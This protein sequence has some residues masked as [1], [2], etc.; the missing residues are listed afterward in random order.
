MSNIT[1]FVFLLESI[2]GFEIMF[3]ST[4]REISGKAN[5]DNF[6]TKCDPNVVDFIWENVNENRNVLKQINFLPMLRPSK[7]VEFPIIYPEKVQ[8]SLE[9]NYIENNFTD[10]GENYYK[11]LINKGNKV[12]KKNKNYEFPS[13]APFL[14]A[15]FETISNITAQTCGGTLLSSHWVLTAASCLDLLPSFYN[16]ITKQNNIHK[17]Y[18]TIVANGK[19]PLVD[20]TIHNVTEIFLRPKNNLTTKKNLK[21]TDSQIA[22][23][24]IEPAANINTLKIFNGKIKQRSDIR[25]YGWTLQK[26]STGEYMAVSSIS[27]KFVN[28]DKCKSKNI[29]VNN[30]SMIC[31][32]ADDE[33]KIKISQMSSGG[34]VLVR[35][36]GTLDILAVAEI[37]TTSTILANTLTNNNW[38]HDIV[39]NEIND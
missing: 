35:S 25:V 17:S 31:L 16:N 28:L 30:N 39:N 36:Q 27:T 12:Y 19:N 15:I 11:Y 5:I 18:Y 22:L 23:M 6:F 3:K 7:V 32:S 29:F 20:G 9:N 13:N 1:V 38:I 8:N 14:V 4:F 10:Y 37:D 34:P 2:P 33:S 21:D 26:N 24:K